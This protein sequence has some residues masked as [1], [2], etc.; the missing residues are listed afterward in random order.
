M[1]IS[2]EPVVEESELPELARLFDQ[3]LKHIDS[4][5]ELITRT[6]P[7]SFYESVLNALKAGFADQDHYIFKAVAIE[8][9][10]NGDQSKTTVG[11][12]H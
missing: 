5:H 12:C 6:Q 10:A 4:F 1:I 2:I 9:L 3:A 8:S 7:E 11:V